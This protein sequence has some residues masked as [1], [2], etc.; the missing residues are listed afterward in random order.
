MAESETNPGL[1]SKNRDQNAVTNPIFITPSDGAVAQNFTGTSGDVNVTN[2]VTVAATDLDIR[3][4][5]HVAAQDSVQ[6]GDGTNLADFVVIDSAYGATPTAFPVAGKFEATPTTYADG[7]AVPFLTDENGRLE[8]IAT[9]TNPSVQVDDAAFTPAVSSVTMVGFFVDEVATDL[10]DEGDG[11]AP[12]ITA[13]RLQ[14]NRLVG[15]VD[16]QRLEINPDNEAEV[17]LESHGLTNI[18]PL[19]ISRDNGANSESNPIFVQEVAQ[20]ASGNEVH[21]FQTDTGLAADTTANHDY[22]AVGTF[23]LRQVTLSA[24]G[25]ARVEVINDATG[26][27]STERVCHLNGRQGDYKE[28]IFTPPLEVAT[29]NIIRLTVK[30][31]QGLVNDIHSSLSGS[32]V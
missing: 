4:L 20:V 17:A 16:S 29:G 5:T 27:P 30:N 3:D 18:N 9:I 7:D 14:L 26:T 10:L 21:R 2:T 25:A 11:G 8:V 15:S 32:D 28:L 22:T 13:S 19:P 23:F 31:R 1:V 6:I 24:T 12:R